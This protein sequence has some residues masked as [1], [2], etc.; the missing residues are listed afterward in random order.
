M[1]TSDVSTLQADVNTLE[2]DARAWGLREEAEIQRLIEKAEF[3]A[4]EATR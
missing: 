3:Y 2:S 1:V 4:N